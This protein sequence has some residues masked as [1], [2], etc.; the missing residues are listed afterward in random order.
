MTLLFLPIL[1]VAAVAAYI[2]ARLLA[3]QKQRGERA[4]SRPAQFGAL[5]LIWTVFPAVVVLI[6]AALITPTV[7]SALIVS[8]APEAVA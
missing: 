6:A 3:R 7:E 2:G 4:H 8:G 5:A 1:L